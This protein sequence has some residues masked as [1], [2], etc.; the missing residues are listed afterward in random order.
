MSQHY[1][2]QESANYLGNYSEYVR[3]LYRNSTLLGQD[4]TVE[5]KSFSGNVDMQC[6]NVVNIAHDIERR[7]TSTDDLPNTTP[8]FGG[9]INGDFTTE[10]E[11]RG[12]RFSFRELN[13]RTELQ[14]LI[15]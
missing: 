5:N 15:D 2:Q 6:Q 10:G 3:Y 4:N 12:Y 7:K 1:M 8:K 11:E 14:A 13:F 9:S